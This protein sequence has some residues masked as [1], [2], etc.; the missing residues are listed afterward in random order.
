MD[1]L[2]LFKINYIPINHEIKVHMPHK[3]KALKN[4]KITADPELAE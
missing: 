3:G 1:S 4:Y 2:H